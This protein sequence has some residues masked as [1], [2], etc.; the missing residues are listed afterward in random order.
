MSQKTVYHSSNSARRP[1]ITPVFLFPLTLFTSAAL[2]F[3]LQPMFGKALL[4]FLG[5]SASVWNTC[6]VFYQSVLFLGYL[7]VY[8][9]SHYFSL[10]RQL[11]MHG[12]VI[13]LSLAALPV[14]LPSDLT[15]SAS[16]QPSLW[17]IQILSVTI[18]LPFFVLST[19]SP[20]LQ[21]WFSIIGHESSADP[22]YLSI[23]SNSGS[24]LA[25]VSYPLLIEAQVGLSNQQVFWSACFAF[26]CL[27]IL[28]CVLLVKTSQHN[29]SAA[30]EIL[31]DKLAAPCFN[32]KLQ[33]LILAFIPSSLLLGVTNYIST[34]IASM[35][36]LWVV[37]LA[38]YLITFIIVFS[39]YSD[40][41]YRWVGNVQF[42]LVA[43]FLIYFFTEQQFI[44]F[45][46]EIAFH[47][48]VAFVCM[49]A[50]HAKLAHIRPPAEH[51][52]TYY[53]TTAL[54]GMLGGMFNSFLAPLLFVNIYEYPLMLVAAVIMLSS[55]NLR[56][57]FSKNN[58]NLLFLIAYILSFAVVLYFSTDQYKNFLQ[59][60]LLGI[61]AMVNLYLFYH[62]PLYLGLY[63]L[64]IMSCSAPLKSQAE[65]TIYQHRDFYGV[66]KIK[67]ST[68][69][70]DSGRK[71]VMH[72]LYNGDT[73]HGAQIISEQ[74]QCLPVSYYSQTGPLGQLFN[75][76][77][78]QNSK[79]NI[80]VVGLGA[81]AIAGY[82]KPGQ[83]WTFFELNP[84]MNDVALNT[85]NFSFLQ[86][87]AKD[88][89]IAIGDARLSL[90]REQKHAYDV[91]IIDA[92]TSDSIPTH[93]L[94][95]EAI[96]LYQANLKPK[97]LL[98]F[99][100]SNRYLALKNILAK[101]MTNSGWAG[102]LEEYRVA[103]P[104]PFASSADWLVLAANNK[105]LKPLLKSPNSAWRPL[106]AEPN[107]YA[108]TDD[109]TSIVHVWK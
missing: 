3:A 25:L 88:A 1:V 98:V 94:T 103:K 59:V 48:T 40:F 54:G 5:G 66:M 13:L 41:V 62:R 86:N 87:C 100:I 30:A 15:P 78:A 74:L 56:P 93:L 91:L 102:M 32:T 38:L 69:Y 83:S 82:A 109:F 6:M 21:K 34:D 72:K 75:A 44:Y 28:S 9:L 19:T 39:Q 37:P 85:Q 10:K 63:A 12:C 96:K 57:I 105:T 84:A 36:L 43:I 47:L 104:S 18:G 8:C 11:L 92:F 68:T 50:C 76:Y 95:A 22:Y 51:L 70:D 80:A 29:S 16:M 55:T 49:L 52:T 65:K 64:V 101:H 71:L 99:H 53:L 23:A 17:L 108:W 81:G 26:L 7:Y 67:E 107:G 79:W 24:L 61:A 42:W 20:L 90:A 89:K 2:M 106:S 97:G 33:W 27:L 77:D 45:S 46:L 4:P 35:P 73:S 58:S 60:G 14:M 31:Q